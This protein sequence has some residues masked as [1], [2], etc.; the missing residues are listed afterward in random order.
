MALFGLPTTLAVAALLALFSLLALAVVAVYVRRDLF[1]PLVLVTGVLLYYVLIPTAYLLQTGRFKIIHTQPND[2]PTLVLDAGPYEVLL[3]ALALIFATYAVIVLAYRRTDP[4]LLPLDRVG[5]VWADD[6]AIDPRPLA[7]IGGVGFLCGIVAYVYYVTV[8]G[9]FVELVTITPRLAFQDVPN[10]GRY[11][12]LAL[13]GVYGG[14]VVTFT[15]LLPRVEQRTLTRK[16]SLA[17]GAIFA[18]T[19]LVAASFRARKNIAIVA[20]Y[21]LLYLYT[22]GRLRDRHAVLGSGGIVVFAALFTFFEH[23]LIAD[24]SP[25]MI[26]RGFVTT[27]R[28]EIFA[29]VVRRV[30]EQYPFQYGVPLLRAFLIEGP[31]PSTEH[32]DVIVTGRNRENVGLGAMLFGELYLNF[33]ALGTLLGG[34]V[35][36]SLLKVVSRTRETPTGYLGAGLYPAGLLIVLSALPISLTWATKSMFLRLVPPIVLALLAAYY[37]RRISASIGRANAT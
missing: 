11:R 20:A 9:G 33:G 4:S 13:A 5:D 1:H 31:L 26:L 8:N 10:T 29:V 15:A 7:W 18:V 12:L 21:L 36:G 16:G 28:L 35:F 22:A 27:A 32:F 34:A 14:Y 25:W 17:L 2:K 19:L 3:P 24:I 30:P 37:Y 23:F 6:H